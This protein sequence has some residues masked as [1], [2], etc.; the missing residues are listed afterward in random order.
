[1]DRVTIKSSTIVISVGEK[2][3][4]YRS[5]DDVP[6]R[7]KKRLHE[8]TNGIN[9]A[10]ILIADR[11]GREEILRAIQGMPNGIRKR[12]AAPLAGDG[13]APCRRRMGW[14]TWLEILLPGAVGLLL[15]LLFSMR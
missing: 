8:S 4:V 13:A 5:L 12:M 6:A 15:W 10:T 7:L 2:T 3:S 11:R 14:R 9:A 1:M